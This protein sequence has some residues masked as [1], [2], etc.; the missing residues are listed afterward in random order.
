MADQ[1]SLRNRVAELESQVQRMMELLRHAS[2]S[3]PVALFPFVDILH[4][5]AE[6]N[7]LKC[8]VGRDENRAPM[9]KVKVPDP[10]PFGDARSAKELE[11][12]LWDMKTYFQSARIPEAE[13]IELRRQ[14]V[15]DLPS[16]IAVADRLVDFR[17]TSSSDL[18]KKKNDSA[19]EIVPREGKLNALVAEED[20]DE[21][22]S[23]RVN[24]M[25]LDSIRSIEKKDRLMLAMQEV[26]DEVAELL[27]EFKDVF[28]PELPKKLPPRKQDGS[29]RM[30][31]DYRA[32]NKV[33]IKNKYPIPNAIDLYAKL[34]KA[35]C[36][37]KIDLRSGYWQVHVARGDEPKTMCVMR[38]FIKGYSKIVNPLTDLLRKDQKQE[39]IV[40]CDDAFRFLKQT[41]SSQPVL[42][43]L[44]FD[45]PFEGKHNDVADALS[46]KLIEEY[47]AAVTVVESDFLDQIRESSRT[48]TGYL[49]LVEHVK[50]GLIR[51]YWLDTGLLYAKGG[52]YG[53]FIVASHACPA[54]TI[55]ELFFKNVTKYFGVPQDIIS[56]KDVSIRS[57]I[58]VLD[59][60]QHV[61]KAYSKVLMAERQGQVN[62]GFIDLAENSAMIVKGYEYKGNTR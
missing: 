7:L 55:A 34:T 25:Q 14:G 46:Q 4:T 9:S 5:R 16:V 51:K 10:K 49:K 31:V 48:D 11:N 50:S 6:V 61:N 12:F 30:R 60:L 20:D 21:G 18:K 45:K 19:C 26:P 44:Q 39:R 1:T 37:T 27:Q 15:K 2:E 32:L 59:P 17:V 36:Y 28:P 43:L 8:V 3:P 53:I 22:G 29:M 47:V 42:E 57:Q 56:D 13:K 40:A 54:E 35:K 41:I 33:T 23:T 52:Q 24:P 38:R 58:L 62:L